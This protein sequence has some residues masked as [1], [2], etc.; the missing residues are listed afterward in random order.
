MMSMGFR[1]IVFYLLIAL[2][3]V[4]LYFAITEIGQ[5]IQDHQLKKQEMHDDVLSFLTE[6]DVPLASKSE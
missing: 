3:V 1:K 2:A 4:L 5:S 6:D